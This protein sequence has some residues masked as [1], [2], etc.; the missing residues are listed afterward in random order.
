MNYT[1]INMPK[2]K[3]RKKFEKARKIRANN[4]T[5]EERKMHP[6][7]RAGDG[8]LPKSKKNKLIIL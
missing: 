1:E 7:L 4:W 3:G 6:R 5:D 8:I 2:T